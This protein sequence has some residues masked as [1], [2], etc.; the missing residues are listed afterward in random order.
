MNLTKLIDAQSYSTTAVISS[1]G[2]LTRDESAL[3]SPNTGQKHAAHRQIRT[4]STLIGRNVC[5]K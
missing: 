2:G 3:D 4:R 1:T 5:I